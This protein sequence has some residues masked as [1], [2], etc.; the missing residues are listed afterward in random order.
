MQILDNAFCKI[1]YIFSFL[2][3][4]LIFNIW[5]SLLQ[6]YITVGHLLELGIDSA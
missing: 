1:L 3:Q 4:K 2:F 5:Q 6:S